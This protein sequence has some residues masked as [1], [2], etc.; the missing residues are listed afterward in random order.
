MTSKQLPRADRVSANDI[1]SLAAEGLQR[2]SAARRA[3]TE[4]SAG[5]TAEVCGAGLGLFAAIDDDWCGTV[6]RRP[7]KFGGVV[8]GDRPPLIN[9]KWGPEVMTGMDVLKGF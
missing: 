8:V 1:A 9:G 5:E 2:A 7:I 3:M 4:L 6:V